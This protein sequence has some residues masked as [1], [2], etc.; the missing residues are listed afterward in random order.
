MKAALA[1]AAAAA[2]WQ[3]PRIEGLSIAP[4]VA[5]AASCLPVT[6]LAVTH[7]GD[8]DI[9]NECWGTR[10]PLGGCTGFNVGPEAHGR[11]NLALNIDGS[12]AGIPG[13][14]L[15]GANTSI[16]G[17]DPPF[18]S[19][20]ANLQAN[21]VNVGGTGPTPAAGSPIRAVFNTNVQGVAI[22]EPRWQ[23]ELL[24]QRVR[25]SSRQRRRQHPV[26]VPL[27]DALT[28]SGV[29]GSDPVSSA[30]TWQG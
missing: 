1:G 12:D 4:D 29:V 21:C 18:Q 25:P 24:L 8:R 2:V 22:S 30:S 16:N 28:I 26:R 5:Q 9:L 7:A 23:Q 17:I 14:G 3:A 15:G 27:I 13:E 11:F 20:T 10:Q 6:P 19:C